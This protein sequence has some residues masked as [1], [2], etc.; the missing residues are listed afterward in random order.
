MVRALAVRVRAGRRDGANVACCGTRLPEGKALLNFF[1]A[2]SE[3][4]TAVGPGRVPAG[5]AAVA[6]ARLTANPCSRET[7][8]KYRPAISLG[9]FAGL[10][11]AQ[12]CG[13]RMVDVDFDVRTVTPMAT[14]PSR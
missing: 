3:L 10:R 11:T 13:L 14:R 2:C 9:A 1:H 7:S 8:P 4:P 5:R 6:A 12:A